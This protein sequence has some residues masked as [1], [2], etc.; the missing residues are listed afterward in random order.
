MPE[1]KFYVVWKGRETGVFDSWVECR[2]AVE[3]YPGA[4]YMSFKNREDALRAYGGRYEDYYRKS[5]VEPEISKKGNKSKPIKKALSVDAACRGNP[6]IMEY[7]GVWVHN[8]K[9]YFRMGPFPEGT[10]NIGEFLAIVHGL[11]SMKR[12]GRLE[13][14]YSDSKTAIKWVNDCRANTKL[15]Q[16]E[17]NRQLF[18]YIIRAEDWLKNNQY[19][20]R[21]LKWETALWGEIPADYGRK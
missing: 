21:I 20:N 14:L 7:R 19:P 18:E 12:D 11:A 6:G 17:I 5:L 4:R 1:R 8:G 9:E 13:P 16:N 10:V 15:E 3:G 2:A